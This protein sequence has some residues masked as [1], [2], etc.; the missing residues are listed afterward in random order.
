MEKEERGALDTAAQR[1]V[2]NLTSYIKWSKAD[3][4][5]D[6]NECVFIFTQAQSP[7]T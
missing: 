5:L 4:P 7:N 2:T 1:K 3:I 6:I